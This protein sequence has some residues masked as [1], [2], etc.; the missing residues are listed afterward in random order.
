MSYDKDQIDALPTLLKFAAMQPNA[1]DEL[2]LEAKAEIE[3]LR[4]RREKTTPLETECLSDEIEKLRRKSERA[5]ML[6]MSA[7]RI[8]RRY[9]AERDGLL[10]RVE[11]ALLAIKES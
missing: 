11:R 4:A 1:P 8:V 9:Q 10:N 7:M 5:H 2:L 3:R 6:Y